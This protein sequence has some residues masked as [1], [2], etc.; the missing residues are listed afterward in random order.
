MWATQLLLQSGTN[1]ILIN[2]TATA[3][4]I[5][6][7]IRS[8][9]SYVAF[10]TVNIIITTNILRNLY[11]Q[12]FFAAF[13]YNSSLSL[14]MMRTTTRTMTMTTTT[15]TMTAATTT[16]DQMIKIEAIFLFMWIRILFCFCLKLSRLLRVALFFA[17]LFFCVNVSIFFVMVDYE[18][19]TCGE[20]RTLIGENY[21]TRG[22]L[23]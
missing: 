14:M 8:S 18:S 2:K 11:S 17:E 21:D 12:H 16:V 20:Q 1:N 5:A 13:L 4:T 22:E 23:N 9:N 3:T 6:T 10:L 7:T 15:T 19:K